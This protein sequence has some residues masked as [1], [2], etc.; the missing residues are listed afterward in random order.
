MTDNAAIQLYC[1]NGFEFI[2]CA[3]HQYSLSF[4][5]ENQHIMLAKV[6]DF[7][8]VKLMY[9]LNSDIYEKVQLDIHNEHEATLNLLMKPLFEDIGMPQ[10]FSY[11]HI[12]KQVREKSI[13]FESHTIKHKRPFGM[14]AESE[15]MPIQRMTCDCAIA[16]PHIIHFTC[17]IAFEPTLNIPSFVEKIVGIIL[18]KIFNKVKQFIENVVV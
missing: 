4:C 9:D 5:M 2:K 10:R 3:Q 11:L 15:L 14:P 8:L 16:S 13:T 18:Y 1:K 6:I 7:N 12:T 17:N